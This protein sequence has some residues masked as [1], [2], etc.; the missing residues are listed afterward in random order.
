MDPTNQRTCGY[1]LND[2]FQLVK[3]LGEEDEVE[4]FT[5]VAFTRTHNYLPTYRY[6]F[7]PKFCIYNLVCVF[8]WGLM[9]WG[10]YVYN[11]IYCIHVLWDYPVT[12][13]IFLVGFNLFWVLM[14]I[15]H[16][17]TV[18]TD[19]GSVPYGYTP[20]RVFCEGFG[21]YLTNE[22]TLQIARCWPRSTWFVSYWALFSKMPKL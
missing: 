19:P 16:L 4:E 15:S 22:V 17:R 1:V 2:R 6:Y 18:F 21:C 20:V 10:L 5:H 13:S 8:V 11:Y 14:L 12:S 3:H 9:G 7:T